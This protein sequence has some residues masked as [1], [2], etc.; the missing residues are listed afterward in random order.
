MFWVLQLGY[1][2]T[3][4]LVLLLISLRQNDDSHMLVVPA[5]GPVDH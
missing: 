1:A 4:L 5:A 2:A 3:L